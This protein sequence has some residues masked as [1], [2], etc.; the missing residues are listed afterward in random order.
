MSF[1][2]LVPDVNVRT[3][4]AGS[5]NMDFCRERAD[6]TTPFWYHNAVTVFSIATQSKSITVFKP[7]ERFAC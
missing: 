2:F 5:R 3:V 1:L 4:F 6:I 7:I